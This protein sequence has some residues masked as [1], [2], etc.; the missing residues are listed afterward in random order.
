MNT[1]LSHTFVCIKLTS[2]SLPLLGAKTIKST[3]QVHT[4]TLMLAR[5]TLA[6]IRIV[7]TDRT[8]PTRRA[9][10]LE[11]CCQFQTLSAVSTRLGITDSL[12]N[13]A[14]FSPIPLRT[15]A[16]VVIW[17]AVQTE[18]SMHAWI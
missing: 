8:G 18:S 3:N 1:R 7:F 12:G 11:A 13:F 17:G 6:V 4:G 10:T 2:W 14:V 9:K 5:G 15:L 16:S